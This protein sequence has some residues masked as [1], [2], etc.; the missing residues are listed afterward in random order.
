MAGAISP[1]APP[2]SATGNQGSGSVER[3]LRDPGYTTALTEWTAWASDQ[4]RG[5]VE[6]LTKGHSQ[7]GLGVKTPLE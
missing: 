7:G 2:G 1:I 4:R 3:R 5:V 6:P